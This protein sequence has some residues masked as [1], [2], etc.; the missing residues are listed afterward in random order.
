MEYS[1]DKSND[2]T[3]S[4]DDIFK[5]LDSI[6][7]EQLRTQGQLK[8]NLYPD[9]IGAWV[10]ETDYGTSPRVA[11]AL[12]KA[13]DTNLLGYMPNGLTDNLKKAC[14]A[15]QKNNFNWDV[16]PENIFLLPDVLTCLHIILDNFIPEK[17]PV[18]VLTP[19]YMPFLTIP[20]DHDHPIIEIPAE[21]DEKGIYKIN[22]EKLEEAFKGGAKLLILCNP[23][24][25]IGRVLSADELN[26]ISEVVSRYDGLVFNDEIHS[27]LVI[28][29]AVQHINY[30][31]V[32]DV[33][34]H[35][36][37]TATAASKGWNI[38]G[39]KS[40]QVIITNSKLADKYAPIGDKYAKAMP[41]IGVIA[42]IAAYTDDSGW[43]EAVREYIFRNALLVEKMLSNVAELEYTKPQGTYLSWIKINNLDEIVANSDL[44]FTDCNNSADILRKSIKVA[45]V[46]GRACGKS[47][48]NYIRLNLAMPKPILEESINKLIDLV[49]SVH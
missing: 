29:S 9:C 40:A 49:K 31:N 15:F 32:N 41:P 34:A 28:D 2:V 46:A 3:V 13:I 6:T 21:R 26:N 30:P 10:A 1:T 25:P 44:D 43:I 33:A 27:S 14:A 23:W 48:D 45:P 4:K 36:T 47:F 12:H 18:I 11:N 37:I 8:W 42:A 22:L 35:H 16:K 38:P 24:N 7:K 17:A 39:L 5:T 19:A 20:L